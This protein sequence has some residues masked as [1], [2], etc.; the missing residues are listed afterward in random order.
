MAAEAPVSLSAGGR[1][2]C[3]VCCQAV[4]AYTCPRC[5]KAYCTSACYKQH[6]QQCTEAF[7]R[8]Q[9]TSQMKATRAD[10][11]QTQQMMRILKRLH[12]QG[13]LE[14]QPH[15]RPHGGGSSSSEAGSE[16]GSEAGSEDEEGPAAAAAAGLD[17]W[18]AQS[19]EFQQLLQ[20]AAAEGDAFE[21]APSDLSAELA[22][23][24]GA[25]AL[26]GRLSH[27]LQPWQPWWASTAAAELSLNAAG[28][29]VVWCNEQ[30]PALY[31]R[32]SL[33][34]AAELREQQA[35]NTPA[36]AGV[37]LG[38]RPVQPLVTQQQQQ[39]QQQQPQK[40]QMS[41]VI[42]GGSSAPASDLYELD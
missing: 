14:D 21:V 20:Q 9:A 34:L 4:A 19:P 28:Q 12:E 22:D 8:E 41:Q 31:E 16:D 36:A 40:Q 30:G 24:L 7:Y 1:R 10:A 23:K 38:V 42:G 32:L 26:S 6:G 39:Q 17:K 2:I 15:H 13:G 37:Q 3:S 27:L 18:L 35:M 5:H 29:R 25:L 11:E 33:Q